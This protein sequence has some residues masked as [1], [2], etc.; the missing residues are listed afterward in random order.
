MSFSS[1]VK[2]ELLDINE[3]SDCC[4]K[5]FLLG[6]MQSSSEFHISNPSNRI[7]IKSTILNTIKICHTLLKKFY[8][9]DTNVSFEDE[10]SLSKR[11]FYHLE[12]CDSVEIIDSELQLS[13]F[14]QLSKNNLILNN[15]CCKNSFIRGLFVGKGSINDPRKNCYHFEIS[16]KTEN[17]AKMVEKIFKHNGIVCSVTE[18][19]NN[20][21]VY[22]KKSEQISNALAL[23]GADS[24]VFYFE[25]QRIVRDISNMA[26]RMTNCDIHN[27]IKCARICEEQLLACE[28]LKNSSIYN[29][30]PTRILA[31]I[32]LRE[33]YPESSYEELSFYSE[34]I[35][36]K[37]LS[38]SGVTHCLKDLMKYYY[39]LIGKEN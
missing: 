1:E 25:D 5:A 9:I 34:N 8:N 2:K 4:K 19:R 26:N 29:E 33:E 15:S 18:R 37:K 20:Y 24:G 35:F 38:K 22:I 14:N 16:L 28:T 23:M 27:E 32:T 11:R 17:L 21:I 36:G 6:I 13:Y 12:I 39:D 30:L 3:L 7:V 10:E 31:T